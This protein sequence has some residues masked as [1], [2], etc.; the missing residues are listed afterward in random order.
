[1]ALMVK[2]ERV[3]C[4]LSFDLD[5]V[6]FTLFKAPF[7]LFSYFV[8]NRAYIYVT[9][10]TNMIYVVRRSSTIN[11]SS[12]LAAIISALF[13]PIKL[14][15]TAASWTDFDGLEFSIPKNPVWTTSLGKR[16]CIIDIDTRPLNASNQILNTGYF[17]WAHYGTTSAGMMGHYLYGESPP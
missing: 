17:D 13:E 7:L 1:M 9:I 3:P 4:Q 2:Q 6:I 5:Y 15:I 12:D 8:I 10:Q 11:P 14:P 16:L